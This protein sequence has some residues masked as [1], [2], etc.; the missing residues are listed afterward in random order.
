MMQIKPSSCV[1]LRILLTC[2]DDEIVRI[3]YWVMLKG[4]SLIDLRNRLI[5][6]ANHMDPGDDLP[7]IDD[8]LLNLILFEDPHEVLQ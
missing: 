2:G 8:N 6:H 4:E 3:C 1:Q 7:V 5:A